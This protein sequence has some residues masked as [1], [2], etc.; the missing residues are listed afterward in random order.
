MDLNIAIKYAQLVNAAY[1]VQT[2]DVS[3]QSGKIVNAGAG[4]ANADYQVVSSVFA[5]D[6]ATD[7]NPNGG[8]ARVSIGLILQSKASGEAVVA[9]R[10]TEGI[11]EWIQDAK[12]LTEPCPFLAAGG[13]TEDG[14]TDMYKSMAIGVAAGSASVTSSLDTLDWIKKPVTSLTICGHSLG[15]SLATLL[16]LDVAANA[17]PP[18]NNPMVYTYASPRTGDTAF[19]NMYNH[20][21][22]NTTRI[23]NRVDLVPKLPLPPLYDHVLGFYDLSSV[24]LLPLPPK[25]LVNPDVVCSHILTT[26]MYLLSVG[27]GVGGFDLTANCKPTI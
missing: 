13:N 12:F 1:A 17:D 10:G 19:V 23:A 2:T 16:A 8:K 9:V 26:Y 21:V 15:G 24:R 3:D 25:V 6:L 14:F 27:A 11:K 20:L 4:A 22:P 5:N 7:M 18:F